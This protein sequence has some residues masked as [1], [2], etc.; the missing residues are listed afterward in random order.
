[1][2]A[3]AWS[4]S[5]CAGSI[6]GSRRTTS[7]SVKSR[8]TARP[9]LTPGSTISIARAPNGSADLRRWIDEDEKRLRA[10]VEGSA[11]DA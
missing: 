11:A 3:S 2:Y 4:N 1:M 8:P 6:V 10:L 7:S 5:N 9:L